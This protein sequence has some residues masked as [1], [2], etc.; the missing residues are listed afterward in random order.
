M[1]ASSVSYKESTVDE[2]RQ[3]IFSCPVGPSRHCQIHRTSLGF[4]KMYRLLLGSP[5]N[6]IS[7]KGKI[8]G[9]GTDRCLGA[10][11]VFRKLWVNLCGSKMVPT[12]R[13][14]TKAEKSSGKGGWGQAMMGFNHSVFQRRQNTMLVS[15]PSSL[16]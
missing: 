16:H 2:R 12:V 11:A 3:E 14:V 6:R 8:R 7:G 13:W 4:G 10:E 1:H 15:P 9:Q 5:T